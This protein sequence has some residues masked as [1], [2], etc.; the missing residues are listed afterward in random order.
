MPS[1][2]ATVPRQQQGSPGSWLCATITV[3]DAVSLPPRRHQAGEVVAVGAEQL[4][5]F[6]PEEFLPHTGKGTAVSLSS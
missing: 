6:T 4:A 3:L 5:G 2:A 1:T